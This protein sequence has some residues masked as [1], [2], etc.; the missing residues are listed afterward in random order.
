MNPFDELIEIFRKFPGVGP[1]QAER[2]VYFLLRQPKASLDKIGRLVPSLANNVKQCQ[3]CKRYHLS[4]YGDG[5]CNICS[6]KNR[7]TSTIMIIGQDVDLK[8]V[9]KSDYNGVYFILGG[10]VP[11]LE[12]DPDSRI[13]LTELKNILEKRQTENPITE[14]IIALNAN[15]EGENTTEIVKKDVTEF[16]QKNNAKIS[17]LGRGLSTGTELE[18]SDSETIKNALKNR[19]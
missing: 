1:R 11:V 18:Y 2:F 15:P 12:K 4:E 8:S 5:T 6:N 10:L 19:F 14:I 17:I 7:D 13:R 16:A 3:L 9:E